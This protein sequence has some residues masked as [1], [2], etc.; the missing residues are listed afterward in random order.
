M[1]AKQGKLENLC[2][3]DNPRNA[4]SFSQERLVIAFTDLKLIVPSPRNS[5]LIC[6]CLV[7]SKPI[8]PYNL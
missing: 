6:K 4:K 1:A 3:Y 2:V 5:G 8:T 7:P